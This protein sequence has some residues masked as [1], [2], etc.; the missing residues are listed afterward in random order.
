MIVVIIIERELFYILLLLLL[1][2]LDITTMISTSPQ[3]S[4]DTIPLFL[5]EWCLVGEHLLSLPEEIHHVPCCL[6][7]LLYL[8]SILLQACLILLDLLQRLSMVFNFKD[9]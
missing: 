1:I 8:L 4:H 2:L 5:V 9:S 6:H 3:L 7:I